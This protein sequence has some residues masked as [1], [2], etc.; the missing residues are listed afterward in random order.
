MARLIKVTDNVSVVYSYIEK[1]YYIYNKDTTTTRETAELTKQVLNIVVQDN[2]VSIEELQALK[3]N[4]ETLYSL[5]GYYSN[6]G[7][8]IAHITFNDYK[9][10]DLI[11]DCGKEKLYISNTDIVFDLTLNESVE[12]RVDKIQNFYDDYIGLYIPVSDWVSIYNFIVS[13]YDTPHIYNSIV[14]EEDKLV[15][16][17]IF[18][19]TNYKV[20]AKAVY[21]CEFNPLQEYSNSKVGD[22]LYM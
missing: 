1:L 22:I 2:K 5:T 10:Y 3:D 20:N 9:D 8:Y 17:N 6:K 21:T 15:Y 11:I 4:K 18:A 7:E 12:Y 19:L 13:Y 16:S 14:R